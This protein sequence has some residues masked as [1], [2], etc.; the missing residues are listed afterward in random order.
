MAYGRWDYR[1]AREFV[2]RKRYS[3][4][5]PDWARFSLE[6]CPFMSVLTQQYQPL[7][8]ARS[9]TA[10]IDE[11]ERTSRR[12]KLDDVYEEEI[13]DGTFTL[14]LPHWHNRL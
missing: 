4:D 12:R 3:I 11:S 7:V 14:G 2:Q 13:K 5:I 1:T 8:E 10:G 6:V 9:Q